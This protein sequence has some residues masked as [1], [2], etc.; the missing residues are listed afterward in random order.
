LALALL[1]QLYLVRNISRVIA[2][3]G[4]IPRL[5]RARNRSLLFALLEFGLIAGLI[6]AFLFYRHVD[7]GLSRLAVLIVILAASVVVLAYIGTGNDRSRIWLAGL[8]LATM[9]A[10]ST[11]FGV[12]VAGVRQNRVMEVVLESTSIRGG[13]VLMSKSGVFLR[14]TPEAGIRRSVFIPASSIKRIAD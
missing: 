2:V 4:R 10:A 7:I 13:I 9:C 14:T 1:S 3:R 12:I 11:Y 6:S 8:Q 5:A